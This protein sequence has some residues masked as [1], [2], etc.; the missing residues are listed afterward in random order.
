MDPPSDLVELYSHPRKSSETKSLT[1]LLEAIYHLPKRVG[2]DQLGG[3]GD[4][5]V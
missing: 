2:K 4:I 3:L 1:F 5:A